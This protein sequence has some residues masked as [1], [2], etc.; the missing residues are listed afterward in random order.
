MK[1]QIILRSIL[2]FPIGITIGY[3]I[4]VFISLKW[5][6]GYYISCVPKLISIMGNEINAVI[7]QTIL[8]GLLGIGFAASSIIWKIENWSIVKQTAIY[9]SIV[10]LIMLP[11]A[12][13]TYWMEH[14]ISGFLQYFGIFV[15]IFIIVWIIQF[16]IGK[17][18]IKK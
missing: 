9:F 5:G 13:F 4:T 7:L 1:K 10:S 12:Y 2:G 11:I 8:C 6:N 15:L 14:S 16:S 17:R 3:L 18:N